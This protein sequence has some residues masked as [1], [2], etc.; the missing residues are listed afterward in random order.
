MS[1]YRYYRICKKAIRWPISYRHQIGWPRHK[2]VSI[3][4]ANSKPPCRY[5]LKY[6]SCR[7]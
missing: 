1:V 5:H 2:Y 3:E 6:L 7:Y 4:L